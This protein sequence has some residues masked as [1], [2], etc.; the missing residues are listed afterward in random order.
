MPGQQKYCNI[1]IKGDVK[2]RFLAK[3]GIIYN[4]VVTL[5]WMLQHCSNTVEA[6]LRFKVLLQIISCDITFI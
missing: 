4:I 6:S 3:P 2:Q 1:I 5:F